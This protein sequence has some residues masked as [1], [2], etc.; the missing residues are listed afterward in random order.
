MK[1][2]VARFMMPAFA[3]RCA[4]R[5]AECDCQCMIFAY[6]LPRLKQ[7]SGGLLSKSYAPGR[8]QEAF[9]GKLLNGFYRYLFAGHNLGISL[10]GYICKVLCKAER[11]SN[12]FEISV[13]MLDEIAQIVDNGVGFADVAELADAQASGACGHNARGGST[14]LIRIKDKLLAARFLASHL[15]IIQSSNENRADRP[16]NTNKRLTNSGSSRLDTV[17][18]TYA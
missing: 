7:K 10:A 9:F 8:E 16:I 5:G 1:F 4:G 18:S 17:R 6:L 12:V 14:P 13:K 15:Q 2:T 3:A 11:S